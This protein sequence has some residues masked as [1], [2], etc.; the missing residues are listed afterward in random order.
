MCV[1]PGQPRLGSPY[2]NVTASVW[3]PPNEF[4][5]LASDAVIENEF[6]PRAACSIFEIELAALFEPKV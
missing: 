1:V 3:L 6:R 2:V 5:K 4:G